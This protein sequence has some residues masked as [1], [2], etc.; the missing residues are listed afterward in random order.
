M[1][2]SLDVEYWTLNSFLSWRHRDSLSA[3][4]NIGSDEGEQNATPLNQGGFW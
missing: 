1:R 4:S 3:V 2:R